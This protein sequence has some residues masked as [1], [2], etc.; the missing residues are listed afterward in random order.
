[1]RQGLQ[2]YCKINFHFLDSIISR[3]MFFLED[4]PLPTRNKDTL[5]RPDSSR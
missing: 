4:L 3:L 2:K 5:K 1:V